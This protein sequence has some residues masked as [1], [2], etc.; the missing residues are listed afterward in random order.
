MRHIPNI[1]SAIRI[2][3]I[4]VYIYF[5]VKT[6]Y[7]ICMI[8]FIAAFFSD[9][10]DG[11]LARKF[12]WISNVGKVLDPLADKLMTLTVVYT[13]YTVTWIPLS[14]VLVIFGKELLMIVGGTILY[15]KKIVVYSDWFGKAAVGL[16]NVAITLTFLKLWWEWIGISNLIV[17]WIAIAC[18]VIALVHYGIKE[19]VI[20]RKNTQ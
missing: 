2:L 4:G 10:L 5:F 20:G 15:F 6:E 7:L 14:M 9:V 17:F 1:I 3:L 12:N 16:F 19:L 11:Y 8:V 13:F 18:A